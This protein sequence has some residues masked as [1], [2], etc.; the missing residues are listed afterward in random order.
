MQNY[1]LPLVLLTRV[2]W[3]SVQIGKIL[4]EAAAHWHTKSHQLLTPVTPL[5]GAKLAKA[6]C[7]KVRKRDE[8]KETKALIGKLWRI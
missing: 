6:A 8:R 3:Q 5:A 2:C 1:N 7:V 4:Q